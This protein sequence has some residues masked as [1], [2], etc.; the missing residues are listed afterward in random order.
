MPYLKIA[1]AAVIGVIIVLWI[2]SSQETNRENA[3]RANVMR[4]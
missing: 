4:D 2:R 3:F 1:T